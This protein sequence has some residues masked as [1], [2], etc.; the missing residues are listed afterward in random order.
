MLLTATAAA[1]LAFFVV[2]GDFVS[3][4]LAGTSVENSKG[5]IALY[6]LTLKATGNSPWL[7]TGYGT[8]ARIFQI[9]RT[10]HRLFRTPA[11]KAH[12]T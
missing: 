3:K 12:N 2:S 9:Y 1:V 10:D 8:Y 6:N 7:G 5:R 4:R 11:L